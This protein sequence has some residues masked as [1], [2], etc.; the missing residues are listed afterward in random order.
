MLKEGVIR[1]SKSP[2]ASPILLRKKKSGEWRLC[3]DYRKLNAQTI[4]DNLDFAEAFVDD[5]IVKSKN[6]EEHLQHTI[7]RFERLRK[8]GYV[9]NPSK[10]TIRQEEVTYLGYTINKDGYKPPNERVEALKNF[11]KPKTI[12]ELR[13]FLGS[14]NYYRRLVPHA[15]QIQI[16]L[17]NY[18]KDSK[19]NDR[20]IIQW[21]PEAEEAFEKCKDSI[22][23]I[24]LTKFISNT[25]PLALITDAS[26]TGI[27]AALEQF[28]D[29]SWTPAGF[30]SRKLSDTETR[31]STYDRELLAIY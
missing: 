10:C 26:D 11:T 8:H 4:P 16:P 13:T 25:T 15:A 12:R 27:G 24:A 22:A 19:K 9:I 20:R 29:G 6:H 14:I 30:F 23:S 18:L 2:W 7:I 17:N 1:P 21:T 5:I 28:V 3:G 31:Y